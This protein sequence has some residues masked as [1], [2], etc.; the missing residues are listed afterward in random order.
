MTEETPMDDTIV[1]VEAGEGAPAIDDSPEAGIEALRQQMTA[2]EDARKQ[3][4]KERDEARRLGEMDR[5]ARDEA[6]R[7]AHHSATEAQTRGEK[8]FQAEY[9]SVINAAAAAN[10]DLVNAKTLLR[11]AMAE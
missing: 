11:N 9:D 5:V 10:S 2:A 1:E 4:E 6:E 3:A 7:R 8:A